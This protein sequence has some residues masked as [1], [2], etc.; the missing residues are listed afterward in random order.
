MKTKEKKARHKDHRFIQ[1]GDE[2]WECSKCLLKLH[3]DHNGYVA[4]VEASQTHCKGASA[5]RANIEAQK[6][7]PTIWMFADRTTGKH[8]VD[9]VAESLDE[10]CQKASKMYSRTPEQ[11][12][13]HPDAIA[14]CFRI[15]KK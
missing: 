8:Y 6:Q 1:V 2:Y 4:D 5:R 15:A 9:C 13:N 7:P 3:L 12:R 14:T 11:W 10:L